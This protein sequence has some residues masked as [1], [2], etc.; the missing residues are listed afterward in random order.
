[1]F[2]TAVPQVQIFGFYCGKK[3]VSV[4]GFRYDGNHNLAQKWDNNKKQL[5]GEFY[6]HNLYYPKDRHAKKVLPDRQAKKVLSGKDRA[7]L[8]N[9]KLFP[10][11]G[12]HRKCLNLDPLVM[13][14]I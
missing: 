4:N 5:E 1:M 8:S 12:N 11:I 3:T 13:R 7:R 2:P 6:Y 10:S 9:T 14:P